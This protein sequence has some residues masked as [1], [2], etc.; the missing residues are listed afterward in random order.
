MRMQ[1]LLFATN[2]IGSLTV[3]QSKIVRYWSVTD[4]RLEPLIRRLLP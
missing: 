3:R 4:H 1:A 2:R